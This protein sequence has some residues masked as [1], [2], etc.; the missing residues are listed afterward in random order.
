MKPNRT[1]RSLKGSIL[2]IECRT[3]G[4]H[5][6]LERKD[7]VRR[8]KASSSLSRIRRGVVGHCERMCADG[9]D[10]CEAR[11][12]PMDELAIDPSSFST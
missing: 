10:Q 2:V 11:L 1:L 9:V 4:L 12:R 6:E 8:F 5:G 7:V 3:C